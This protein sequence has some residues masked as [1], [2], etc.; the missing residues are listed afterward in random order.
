MAATS[1]TTM[2]GVSSDLSE[3]KITS[4]SN[5]SIGDQE[6]SQEEQ[7]ARGDQ[8]DSGKNET[9]AALLQVVGAFFLMFNSW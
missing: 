1:N 5:S 7:P 8:V 4:D 2:E 6:K 3:D 9:V